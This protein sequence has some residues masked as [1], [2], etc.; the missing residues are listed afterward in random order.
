MKLLKTTVAVA[1]LCLNVSAAWAAGLSAQVNSTQLAQGDSFQL[2][3]TAR[4]ATSAPDLTPLEQDFDVLGTSQSSQTQI[5]N[6]QRSQSVSWIIT[7]APHTT[8]A[9]TIPV[10]HAGALSSDP[11]KVQVL[12]ASQLPKLQGTTGISLSTKIDP[13]DH[14]QFQEI[15]LTVRIETAQP[16]QSA[17]LIAPTG[18][19]ELTRTG[20]DRQS[21]ITRNGQPITVIERDYLLRP[22]STGTL[23]V[24]AFTLKGAVPGGTGRRGAFSS[25]FGGG[26]PFAMM[27]QM[28]ARMGRPGGMGM[29]SPFADMFQSGKPFVARSDALTLTVLANPHAGTSDWF[30]PAKA[31]ELRATWQPET[32]N[33]REG[34]AVTRKISL[35]ALGARPEQ[36]PNLSFTDPAGARLYVDNVDTDMV[37]TPDGTAARRDF[38]L[39]IVPTRGGQVTLPE[40]SVEW[41]DTASGETKVATIPAQTISV[42]GTPPAAAT[43]SLAPSATPAPAARPNTAV[44]LGLSGFALL[45]ALGAGLVLYRRGRRSSPPAKAKPS[46]NKAQ[47]LKTLAKAASASDQRAFYQ[48]LLDLRALTDPQERVQ[49]DT[50]LAQL[51]QA[52]YAPAQSQKPTDLRKMLKSLTLRHPIKDRLARRTRTDTLPALYPT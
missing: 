47:V 18:D 8:G 28:M 29:G 33:F 31:V 38:S 42:E 14:Y 3:L 22:D 46:R 23:T 16:L 19:F 25:P 5:I 1:A 35:L 50:A 24:P 40:I 15:P 11:L 34:E 52:A 13:G 12:D 6:G 30:L 4:Q 44:E 36:L 49:I 43:Q 37:E 2:V 27:D 21:Q 10:L 7:L 41:L 51:E 45:A 9:L 26:D 48:G 32:P 39:S 17:E 20:P